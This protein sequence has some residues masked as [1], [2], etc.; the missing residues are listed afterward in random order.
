MILKRRL[1]GVKQP[2]R[3][4]TIFVNHYFS[5]DHSATSQLLSDLSFEL[6]ASDG[7]VHVIA[8]RQ[9][10]DNWDALLSAHE[11]IRGVIVHR[12]WTSRFD[13]SNVLLRGVDYVTFYLTAGC[14]LLVFSARGD[15][16]WPKQILRL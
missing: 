3:M 1:T 15:V 4:K 12:V 9:R 8:S 5:L 2:C 10:Y 7:N 14:K 16:V 13:R 11:E 6:A